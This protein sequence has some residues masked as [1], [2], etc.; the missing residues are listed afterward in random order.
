MFSDTPV[1]KI[2]LIYTQIHVKIGNSPLS[3]TIVFYSYSFLIL[4]QETVPHP[5]KDHSLLP[6]LTYHREIDIMIAMNSHAYQS[7]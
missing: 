4:P 6:R 3:R 2:V 7:F 5:P 1:C